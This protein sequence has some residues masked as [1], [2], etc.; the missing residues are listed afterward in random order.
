MVYYDDGYEPEI[1]VVKGEVPPNTYRAYRLCNG[2][3]FT[4]ENLVL[5][6]ENLILYE[7]IED[8]FDIFMQRKWK[9]TGK[10]FT[11]EQINKMFET[12]D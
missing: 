3:I 10:S 7:V 5:E 1:N 9:R 4:I 2:D 11:P 8:G 6:Y 12:K